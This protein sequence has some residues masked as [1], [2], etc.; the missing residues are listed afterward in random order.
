MAVKT[1]TDNTALPASDINTFLANAGLVHVKSQ[2]IGSAVS[3]VTVTNAFNSTY[4]NYKIVVS[5]GTPS[6]ASGSL[7]LK[8]G[9]STTAYYSGLWY[10][11]WASATGTLLT[12]N[13]GASWL[14]AIA[15][16]TNGMGGQIDI[17]SPNLAKYT[18]MSGFYMRD[19]L[20]GPTWGIHAVGTAYTECTLTVSVGTLTGGTIDI[21][22]YRKG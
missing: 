21:Y 2:T 11:A 13:N 10:A 22:G 1:F 20:G 18:R 5:A 14:Y 19:D 16:D 7:Q 15:S 4:D 3:S 6:N 12:V 8:L 9:S 17:F